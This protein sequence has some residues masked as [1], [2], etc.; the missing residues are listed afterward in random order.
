MMLKLSMCLFAID[1]FSLM[2]CP[3]DVFYPVFLIELKKNSVLKRQTKQNASPSSFQEH[4][5]KYPK[6]R[7]HLG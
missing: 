7:S 1:T 3:I 6:K 4:L 5:R 2:K